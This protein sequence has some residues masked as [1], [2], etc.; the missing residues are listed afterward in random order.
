MQFISTPIT[1]THA[2]T[3]THKVPQ[4]RQGAETSTTAFI[5]GVKMGGGG[6]WGGGGGGGGGGKEEILGRKQFGPL[7]IGFFGVHVTYIAL[8]LWRDQVVQR[9][10]SGFEI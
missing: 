3:H 9:A 6:G 10:G 2:R 7:S 4:H 1:K 8:F 5:L